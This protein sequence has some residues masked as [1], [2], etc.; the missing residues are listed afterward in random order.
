MQIFVCGKF[1]LIL[2]NIIKHDYEKHI[3]N[4]HRFFYLQ[5]SDM[6]DINR[7]VL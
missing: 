1:A 3:T 5:L 7:D 6:P 4:Y 2:K